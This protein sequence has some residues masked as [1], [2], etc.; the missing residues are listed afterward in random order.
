[1]GS[2]ARKT[3]VQDCLDKKQNPLSKITRQKGLEAYV[4][5]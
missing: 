5:Q 1:M 3:V 2:I 4:K